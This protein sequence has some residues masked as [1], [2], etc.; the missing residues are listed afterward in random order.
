MGMVFILRMYEWVRFSCHGNIWM[1][2]FFSNSSSCTPYLIVPKTTHLYIMPFSS[3]I[4]ILVT[5]QFV[6]LCHECI[7]IW[8][9]FSFPFFS[10]NTTNHHHIAEILLKVALNTI[11]PTQPSYHPVLLSLQRLQNKFESHRYI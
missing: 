11:N 4:C 8:C 2:V 10:T 7:E 6:K 3:D 1:G 9:F 5:K